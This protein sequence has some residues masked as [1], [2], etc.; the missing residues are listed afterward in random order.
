MM[1]VESM[2]ISVINNGE[3]R[4][5][6]LLLEHDEPANKY[7]NI[8]VAV[9]NAIESDDEESLMFLKLWASGRESE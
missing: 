1:T 8:L 3:Q 2:S 9:A 4:F 7:K 5:W 6:A